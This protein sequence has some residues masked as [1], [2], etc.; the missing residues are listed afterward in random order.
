MPRLV[1]DY[2]SP[3]GERRKAPR[4]RPGIILSA[5]IGRHD[6]IVADLSVSGARVY[7][8]AA[9]KRGDVV[10]FSMHH[11]ARVISSLARVL[12]SAVAALGTGPSGAPT[13][14][15]RLQFAD[16]SQDDKALLASLL[17]D[18]QKRQAERWLRNAKGEYEPEPPAPHVPFYFTR[19]QWNGRRWLETSTRDAQQPDDGLTIP[20]DTR[21]LERRMISEVYER[22]DR[23]GRH[24][25]RLVAAAACETLSAAPT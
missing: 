15:S 14:E 8:F 23:T 11:G 2:L 9:V 4:Y 19:M 7:H 5:L 17:A 20:A 21:P 13:Y 3:G 22:A 24:L 10:R 1:Y 25:M 12:S 16:I 18:L 6:A